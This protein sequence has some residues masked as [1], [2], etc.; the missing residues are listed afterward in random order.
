[1]ENWQTPVA[2]FVVALAAGGLL[3]SAWHRRHRPGTG[4]GSGGA[5]CGC[6]TVKKNLRVK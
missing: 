4:C 3:W 1:M 2:L 6:D 5:G